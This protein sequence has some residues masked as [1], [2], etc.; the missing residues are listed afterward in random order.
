MSALA[1]LGRFFP[2]PWFVSTRRCIRAF[3]YVFSFLHCVYDTEK[4][5][6]GVA[7]SIGQYG[8]AT[9]TRSRRKDGKA[10][11]PP[12]T[13]AFILPQLQQAGETPDRTDGLRG[14]EGKGKSRTWQERKRHPQLCTV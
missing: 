4:R 12:G 8:L 7:C 11:S 1:L 13:G 9:T 3:S 2:F 10:Y 14:T 6:R 5:R